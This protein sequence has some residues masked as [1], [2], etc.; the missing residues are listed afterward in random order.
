MKNAHRA[1]P[2]HFGLGLVALC[3]LLAPPPLMA[4]TP[5][6]PPQGDDVRLSR[7]IDLLD[8]GEAVFGIIS[9]DRSLNNAR[10][11]ARSGLDFIII[12]MEH[13]P[14][15]PETLRIFL[16]GAALE[17]GDRVYRGARAVGNR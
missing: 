6:T 14:W 11:L 2:S 1:L 5:L 7:V 15:S 9:S 3:I 16:L 4:S 13:G 10:S 17:D 8:G 12:D